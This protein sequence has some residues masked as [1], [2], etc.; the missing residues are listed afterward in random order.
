MVLENIRKGR[1]MFMTMS[2]EY[3]GRVDDT[4]SCEQVTR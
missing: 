1:Q 2:M 4:E 3:D